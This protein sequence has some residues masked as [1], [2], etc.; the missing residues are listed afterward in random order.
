MKTIIALLLMTSVASAASEDKVCRTVYDDTT[1]FAVGCIMSPPETYT[2]PTDGSPCER[3]YF[4]NQVQ[5]RC[6]DMRATKQVCG[7]ASMFNERKD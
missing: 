5:L 3:N 4:T 1:V 2:C 7:P 6:P